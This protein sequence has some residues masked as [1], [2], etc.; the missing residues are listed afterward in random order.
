MEMVITKI[1][2]EVQD[3]AANIEQATSRLN[4]EFEQATS[5]LN[6]ELEQA[7]QGLEQATIFPQAFCEC[8]SSSTTSSWLKCVTKIWIIDGGQLHS[9]EEMWSEVSGQD[10]SKEETEM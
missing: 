4:A 7:K 10:Y 5:R 1:N 3:L 9:R 2:K 8:S 6:S